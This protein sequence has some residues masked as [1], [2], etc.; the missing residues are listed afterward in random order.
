M[1]RNQGGEE[2]VEMVRDGEGGNERKARGPGGGGGMAE[3]EYLMIFT[4]LTKC[5]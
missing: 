1:R 2:E 4:D 5:R 3:E